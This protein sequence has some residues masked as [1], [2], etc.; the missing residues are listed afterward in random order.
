MI[1]LANKAL[2]G[3]L[4]VTAATGTSL[5][6]SLIDELKASV[7]RQA[8]GVCVCV[9]RVRVCVCVCDVIVCDTLSGS[10]AFTLVRSPLWRDERCLCRYIC[11]I[12]ILPESL[13]CALL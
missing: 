11:A 7:H 13:M 10:D 1:A 12:A 3:Q 6:F 4:S 9:V 5:S 8:T 2:F